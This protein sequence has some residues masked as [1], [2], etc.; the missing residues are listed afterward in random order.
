MK[1]EALEATH[2]PKEIFPKKYTNHIPQK[3]LSLHQHQM[4]GF[5]KAKVL[6]FQIQCCFPESQGWE[7][8]KEGYFVSEWWL[9]HIN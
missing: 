5:Q 8:E 1:A 7:R 6:P 3:D 2:Q 4:I 9:H